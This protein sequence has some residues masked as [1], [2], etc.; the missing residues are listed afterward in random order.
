MSGAP[1]E[2][3][4]MRYLHFANFFYDIWTIII[5]MLE[6]LHSDSVSG[7]PEADAAT[8]HLSKELQKLLLQH[9]ELQY[10]RDEIVAEQVNA[11][12]ENQQKYSS[13]S[14]EENLSKFFVSLPHSIT[15]WTIRTLSPENAL[16][17]IDAGSLETEQRPYVVIDPFRI[18][19]L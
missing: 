19:N 2:R 3:H 14:T 13:L 16:L 5:F 10:W 12:R 6:E 17:H 18:G 9:P 11:G 1:N 7:L 8:N 4:C 15:G